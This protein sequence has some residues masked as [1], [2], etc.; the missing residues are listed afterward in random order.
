MPTG[1]RPT[2]EIADYMGKVTLVLNL[3]YLFSTGTTCSPTYDFC[4]PC[5][6][7]KAQQLPFIRS[8][9]VYTNPLL[10]VFIDVWGPAPIATRNRVRYYIAFIDAYSRYT[11][12]YLL[13]ARSQV[14]YVFINFKTC[15]ETQTTFKL[16]SLQTDNAKE[17][18]VLNKLLQQY[19]IRFR[20][21]FPHTHEQNGLVE[22]KHC[23]KQNV[24]FT[25]LSGASL[26]LKY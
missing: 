24:G 20:L 2:E 6:L 21:I 8:T 26:P 11:W 13:H 23:L 15:A 9:I 16:K 17:F 3:S 12:L 7:A 18:F 4:E 19:G 22:R 10:M 25:I 1:K 5:I 14:A